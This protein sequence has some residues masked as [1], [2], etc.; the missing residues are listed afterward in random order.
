MLNLP[1][2][3]HPFQTEGVVLR[4]YPYSDSDQILQ[5]LSKE[6]GLIRLI[7]KGARKPKSRLSG[8]LEP[9][10]LLSFQ[11]IRGQNLHRIKTVDMLKSYRGLSKDY[12]RLM[13]GFAMGE[14]TEVFAQEGQSEPVL[15]DWFNRVLAQLER[16][17]K[18]RYWLLWFSRQ[19]LQYQGFAQD[20]S[21]CALCGTELND[22]FLTYEGLSCRS[23]KKGRTQRVSEAQ[24]QLFTQLPHSQH[25]RELLSTASQQEINQMLYITHSEVKFITDKELQ[26]FAYLK[27]L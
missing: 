8:R 10:N 13:A 23:C 15:F 11:L 17:E 26:S 24:K 18:P 1:P 22:A 4:R 7:A 3:R 6:F 20:Y 14:L 12:E 25:P 5:V 21:F 19:I 27:E 9:L 2:I 16:S